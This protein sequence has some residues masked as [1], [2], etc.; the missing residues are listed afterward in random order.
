MAADRAK[1]AHPEADS[2]PKS[3][4]PHAGVFT[5][6]RPLARKWALLP[7]GRRRWGQAAQSTRRFHGQNASAL[8][9]APLVDA[10]RPGRISS[11]RRTGFGTLGAELRVGDKASKWSVIAPAGDFE[12]TTLGVCMR[13]GWK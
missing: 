2:L 11:D 8:Q 4:L 5:S 6:V 10:A 12:L 1:L 7:L 9:D 3:I 13:F